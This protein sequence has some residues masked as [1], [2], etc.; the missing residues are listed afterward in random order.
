MRRFSY[1]GLA[2]LLPVDV[3]VLK[4][5]KPKFLGLHHKDKQETEPWVQQRCSR[6]QISNSN[7]SSALMECIRLQRQKHRLGIAV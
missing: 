2:L 6:V 7:K 5:G 1:C 3:N 4:L